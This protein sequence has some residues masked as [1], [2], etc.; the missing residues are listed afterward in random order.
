MLIDL[1]G[2][3]ESLEFLTERE[4]EREFLAREDFA[5]GIV[6]RVENDRLGAGREG[7]AELDGIKAPVRRIESDVAGGGAAE[8]R[9]GIVILV[10]RLEDDHLVSRIEEREQRGDHAFGSAQQTVT[11]HSGSK[12]RP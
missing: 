4:N 7:A 9:I 2:D 5:G 3:G 1:V 10:E 11:S 8:L 12:S 6:G